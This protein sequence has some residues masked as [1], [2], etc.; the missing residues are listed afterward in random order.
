MSAV[1]AL[2]A[3]AGCVDPGDIDPTRLNRYQERLVRLGP[4]NRGAETGL[5][6]LIPQ[7]DEKVPQFRLEEI[8]DPVTGRKVGRIHLTLSEVVLMALASNTDIRAA[9]ERMASG[10]RCGSGAVWCSRRALGHEQGA[11]SERIG[12]LEMA[13]HSRRVSDSWPPPE[14]PESWAA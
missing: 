10:P 3:V 9:R 12:L 6:L 7:R 2:G 11:R 1:L 14:R 8:T 5:D 13:G 4:Q